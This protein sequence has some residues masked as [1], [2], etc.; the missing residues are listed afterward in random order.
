[1]SPS[2]TTDEWQI[3]P[4]ETDEA[5]NIEPTGFTVD[6]PGSPGADIQ[7]PWWLQPK[8][9]YPTTLYPGQKVTQ[10]QTKPTVDT[11]PFVVP[12]GGIFVWS[13][14]SVNG[15]WLSTA[16]TENRPLF[17]P[18]TEPK[19]TTTLKV[20]PIT[21]PSPS[22]TTQTIPQST[23]PSRGVWVIDPGH[24]PPGFVQPLAPV[25]IPSTHIPSTYP[26]AETRPPVP[27]LLPVYPNEPGQN[28]KITD[29]GP[30]QETA[31][32]D[33]KIEEPITVQMTTIGGK[34]PTEEYRATEIIGSFLLG[35][36]LTDVY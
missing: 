18:V 25:L 2:S 24:P 8:S 19:E 29:T 22:T 35:S 7:K 14:G 32:T 4:T 12:G 16:I 30:K 31:R 23:L 20:P 26:P 28:V 11:E 10:R 17:V 27:T 3:Y 13:N 5:T 21:L 33:V 34:W 9:T 15:P 6:L 1:M 36:Y